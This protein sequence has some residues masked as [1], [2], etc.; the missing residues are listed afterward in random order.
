MI[1]VT[2]GAGFI[3]S[4]LVWTLN[5]K[6][7]TDIT[8]VDDVD[9]DEKEHNI[10]H[11]QYEELVGIDD[12]R[13]RLRN[14]E[15]D[16]RNVTGIFHLGAISAT[17]EQNWKLLEDRNV[18]YSKDIIRWCVD[19]SVRCIYASSGQ[20]YGFGEKGYSDDHDLFDELEP[21][22][23][24]GKSKLLVDI[25]ARDAGYLDQV[26]GVRYFNVFGPNE[27]HK[28]DMMSVLC[29][30]FPEIQA[31]KPMTLFKSDNP[32]Y[33]D[34]GQKRD[35]IY[36]QDVLKATLYFFDNSDVNGVFNIG[37]GKARTWNDVASAM[38]QAADKEPNIEYV[39]MP[40]KL[41]GKYQYFT[42]A[43][44]SKLKN[45]GYKEKMMTLEESVLDYVQN[46]LIPHKH[47]G[48]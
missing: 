34:G 29:K 7:E 48:E 46:Y 12:F 27:Y 2:G 8:I 44:T 1:I 9:H 47:L 26:V 17:T 31:G 21:F 39:E 6:G 23:L 36:I 28:G 41:K 10:G 43:D 37:T 15:Y 4:G 38:F 5:Q 19:R 32:D 30:K 33:E 22:S 40:D 16:S 20:T 11:L 13:E 25:W 24:Y 18:E 45:A 42:E 35:F 3:G 14:G